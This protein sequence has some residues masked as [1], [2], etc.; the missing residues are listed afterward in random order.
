[1]GFKITSVTDGSMTFNSDIDRKIQNTTEGLP[2][3]CLNYLTK[4][5]LPV[6]RENVLTICDYTSSLKSGINPSRNYKSGTIIVLR[7][8]ILQA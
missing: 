2:S 7:L 5:V 4:R 1:M 3:E 8:D 6:S